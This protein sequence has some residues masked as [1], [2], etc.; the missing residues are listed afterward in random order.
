MVPQ[1]PQ[2]PRLQKTTICVLDKLAGVKSCLLHPVQ[3]LQLQHTGLPPH[4][5]NAD[6]VAVECCRRLEFVGLQTEGV[7]VDVGSQCMLLVP[8]EAKKAAY[9]AHC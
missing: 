5:N 1:D 3:S 2:W 7:P 9:L 4:L 8:L 6:F